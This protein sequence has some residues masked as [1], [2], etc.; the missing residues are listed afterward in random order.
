MQVQSVRSPLL[1]DS[2]FEKSSLHQIRRA[3]VQRLIM[4]A[5]LAL[6]SAMISP[7]SVD[8]AQS[9]SQ[10]QTQVQSTTAVATPAVDAQLY[11]FTNHGCTPCRQVEPGIEALAAEGYPVTTIILNDH[12]DWAE[13]FQVNRTPT[14]IL[15]SKNQIVG[16][17]AGLI[18]GVTLKQWF[19]AVGVPT[20][21]RFNHQA[22]GREPVGT[23]VSLPL[24]KASSNAAPNSSTLHHG[25]TQ[26]KTEAERRAM[27]ATVRLKVEDPEGI[28]YATGTVIHCHRGEWLVMTCGHVFRE[29]KGTGKIT[30]EFGFSTG[31]IK[32]ASGQ[33]ISY[34]AEARDIALVAIAANTEV[35]PVPLAPPA[36]SVDRGLTVF[37][38]GCD[39]GDAPT[40]RHSEIKNRAA[41]DGSLKYDIY[42]RP[43]NG[44][45]GGGLFTD[46]GELIGVCN[47]AAVDVDEGIYTA[48]ETVHW[49]IAEVKLQH[50]FDGSLETE[51]VLAASATTAVVNQPV[52][53]P[54]QPVKIPSRL[55]ASLGPNERPKFS[56]VN[57]NQWSGNDVRPQQTP[58]KW[59]Y[60]S[61]S[62]SNPNDSNHI[63]DSRAGSN[64]DAD[65]EVIIIVRSKTNP[66]HAE[67]IT[68]SHPSHELLNYLDTMQDGISQPRQLDV[69]RLR[70]PEPSVVTR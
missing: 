3:M 27:I 52:S 58:A 64:V 18:D 59:S 46:S 9:Q 65:R 43:V 69:A 5:M 34:D 24:T 12:P 33:L 51:S 1:A 44:R 62:T 10:S 38:I 55:T 17:H 6:V 47:A 28:S 39:Q 22:L 66:T 36:S 29:S 11:F 20:G 25:T 70:E 21:S 13:R 15:V 45:S 32:T 67:A 54:M 56:Q 14:V 61:A 30:A 57:S 31:E 40:I 53:I 68:V 42:G 2:V 26:P 63:R 37:S 49:Q 7:P 60:Q 48:L 8:A 41:Y 35:E 19:A 4:L 23:K 50:L 16:R